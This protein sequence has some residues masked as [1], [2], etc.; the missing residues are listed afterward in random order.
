[1]NYRLAMSMLPTDW[2]AAAIATVIGAM[3]SAIVALIVAFRTAMREAKRRQSEISLDVTK[4]LLDPE[5]SAAASRRFAVAVVKVVDGWELSKKGLV[6]FIPINSRVTIGRD[7]R[8]DVVL[9]VDDVSRF[10][11]G[12]VSEGKRVF[13]EDYCST[14]GVRVNGAPV[15]RGGGVRLRNADE[16]DICGHRLRFQTVHCSKVLS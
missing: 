3:A 13:I 14:N 12:L 7:E 6:L 16:I 2:P 15:P 10:H 4:L 11:C 8:N 1:M 9:D 5:K